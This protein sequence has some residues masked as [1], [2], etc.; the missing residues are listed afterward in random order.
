MSDNGT[1]YT[2]GADE[3]SKLMKSEEIATV[4]GREGT[5]WRFIPKKTSWFGGYWERLIEDGDQED[6]R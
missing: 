5:V 2:S 1:T 6:P 4:L 3:L